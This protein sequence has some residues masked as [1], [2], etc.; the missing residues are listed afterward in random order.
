L[1]DLER[2][3]KLAPRETSG[4]GT[5]DKTPFEEATESLKNQQVELRNTISAYS[6]LRKSGF[7][8]ST[9]FKTAQNPVL[10]TALAGE[11]INTEKWRELVGL[12]REY[13]N[14]QKKV[15]L[16][17]LIKQ[18][19][20][21]ATDESRINRIQAGLS[22]LGL[23]ADQISRVVDQIGDDPNLLARFANDL[24]DGKINS[25]EISNYLKGIKNLDVKVKIAVTKEEI[26]AEADNA[27]S[28]VNEAFSS[29]KAL[30]EVDFEQGTNES[31]LNP[32]KINTDALEEGIKKS[33]KFIQEQND[34]I[35][36]NEYLLEGIQEQEDSINKRYD[37]R[38]EAI[39]AIA[40]A[41]EKVS[42]AQQSQLSISSALARG[43]VASA[44][45]LMQE[46]QERERQEAL[47]KRRSDIEKSREQELSSIR[48]TDGRTRTQIEAEIKDLKRQVRIEEEEN[49]KPQQKSLDIAN[50]ILDKA[51]DS[52]DVLG[53]N[54][55]AWGAIEA[56]AR[57][58]RVEAEAYEKAILGSLRSGNVNTLGK[59]AL[60]EPPAAKDDK[61]VVVK[62]DK[63]VVVK[64][65][66]KVVKDDRP[67]AT[68]NKNQK[69]SADPGTGFIWS[70]DK[71]GKWTKKAVTKPAAKE[72]FKISWNS[73]T[74]TWSQ[75]PSARPLN[76]PKGRDWAWD[77]GSETWKLG[78]ESPLGSS[79]NPYTTGV[80]PGASIPPGT[81][82][83]SVPMG[84]FVKMPF[85]LYM[86][87]MSAGKNGE[88]LLR[89][90]SEENNIGKDGAPQK[91]AG[92]VIRIE[93]DLSGNLPGLAR[94]NA[95]GFVSGPGTPTSDSIPAM[96]SDGEYVVKASSVDKIGSNV[97]EFLN[98]NGK[99]PGFAEGGMPSSNGKSM[100]ADPKLIN[101]VRQKLDIVR[102]TEKMVTRSINPNL[103]LELQDPANVKPMQG[104]ALGPGMYFAPNASISERFWKGLGGTAYS[105]KVGMLDAIR[106]MSSKGYASAQ[107]VSSLGVRLDRGDNVTSPSVRK[108]MDAGYIGY[109]GNAKPDLSDA[110]E[111]TNWKIGAKNGFGLK[112]ILSATAGKSFG[113][114]NILGLL[115]TLHD[116]GLTM[117]GKKSNPVM[118][119][120]SARYAMGGLVKPQYFNAG[121][122]VKGYSRGGDV[123]PSMLTPGE[124]V[125]S[126]FAV[127]NYGLDKMKA[128][129]SGTY[130][131]DSVYNYSVNVNVQSESNPDEI[132]RTVMTQI[133][134]INDQ[135]IRSYRA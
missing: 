45:K 27:F 83:L 53:L 100:G 60:P 127:Q 108:L 28:M 69:P 32:D 70:Q 128:I 78:A 74:G 52:I 14:L 54:E 95:G 112:K 77:K 94:F 63:K 82:T 122:M 113:A 102:A 99:L 126:K 10:A 41:N 111:V 133:K 16:S 12:I 61:K 129:N 55:K 132:A 25:E 118:D 66:K 5:P 67:G 43:D 90:G 115:P 23:T 114:L 39:D 51:I 73:Q 103:D 125:M 130:N 93:R 107:D 123:V 35:S 19:I 89:Y 91:I 65:D 116:A 98:N 49:L 47:E 37:E 30:I 6:K 97:L 68:G 106:L 15:T 17:D 59:L 131:G 38:L 4:G 34:K 8:I 26:E 18:N 76:T 21:A 62:D 46:Q 20:S 24:R 3:N 120:T 42:A 29:K 48:G 2:Y 44:A 110:N 31:Q 33:E 117:S 101:A 80:M 75:T 40:E 134:R 109:R 22:K 71:S 96:L 86:H 104:R 72:G 87:G 50:E 64:D 11:K 92:N 81:R 85:G 124:F 88:V 7:D 58:A 135:Q 84:K 79:A 105:P 57:A 121:G 9:A 13:N 56:K 36:D 119:R 1:L